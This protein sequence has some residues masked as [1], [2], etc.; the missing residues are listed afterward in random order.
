[1]TTIATSIQILFHQGHDAVNL[2]SIG[3]SL[4]LMEDS[5][6]GMVGLYTVS[7]TKD[8]QWLWAGR[9]RGGSSCDYAEQAAVDSCSY[10]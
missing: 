4:T 5:Q 1:M 8:H 9:E 10:C 7:N 6:D 2:P 3:L